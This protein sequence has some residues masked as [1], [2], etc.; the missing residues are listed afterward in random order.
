MINTELPLIA[1]KAQEIIQSAKTEDG[2]MTKE[3]HDRLSAE[4]RKLGINVVTTTNYEDG[5]ATDEYGCTFTKV[6]IHPFVE[7]VA[8]E[9]GEPIE[10][11]WSN[12]SGGEYSDEFGDDLDDYP[13]AMFLKGWSVSS[14]VDDGGEPAT[15]DN[16][17]FPDYDTAFARA[18]ELAA[19]YRV[20]IDHSY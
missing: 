14:W 4:L 16:E 8:N 10:G 5:P 19:L 12:A 18:E 3:E 1:R 13:D 9:D 15:V 2:W 6:S 17:E 11:D 7:R 20:D